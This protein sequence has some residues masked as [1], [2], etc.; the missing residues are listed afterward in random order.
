MKVSHK[1]YIHIKK[2]VLTILN[3]YNDKNSR[4]C[5][6]IFVCMGAVSDETV[7]CRATN[8]EIWEEDTCMGEDICKS[9][10]VF[11]F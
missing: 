11:G 1:K 7:A 6:C 4:V 8:R 2:C 3:F 9:K 10:P 5:M